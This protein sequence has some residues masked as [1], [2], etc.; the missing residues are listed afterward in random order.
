MAV[1]DPCAARV[2]GGAAAGSTGG[3]AA[4]IAGGRVVARTEVSAL[5]RQSIR[6][7]GCGA[8][9]GARDLVGAAPGLAGEDSRN[10]GATAAR[11]SMVCSA[12]EL[13][14]DAVRRSTRE[15]SED[16]KK[17]LTR[18]SLRSDTE[19]T[20]KMT[21]TAEMAASLLGFC[22]GGGFQDALVVALVLG[23]YVVGAKLFLGV[24]AGTLAHF[25][26]AIGARQDF[27]GVAAGFLYIA[28][29]H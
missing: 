24:D 14:G 9:C 20:E 4:G 2:G 29:F 6:R 10:D 11:I 19:G 12:A 5:G 8:C 1:A 16:K 3:R 13:R 21:S 25:A 23:D 26:A 18:S 17:D 15:L 27:D 22:G 7:G 28:G